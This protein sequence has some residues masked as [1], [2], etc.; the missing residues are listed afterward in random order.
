M[1]LGT[2]IRRKHQRFC[3]LCG[4]V[5][6]GNPNKRSRGR[7][8]SCAREIQV[9]PKHRPSVADHHPDPGIIGGD[10]YGNA[11]R[12]KERFKTYGVRKECRSCPQSCKQYNAPNGRI[13]LC[14]AM[15]VRI[16]VDAL[17]A[18][19]ILITETVDHNGRRFWGER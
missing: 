5:L 16:W 3:R 6:H 17:P 14:P 10:F 9:H 8:L 18:T 11:V 2:S 4:S 15:D 13:V 12:V 1:K 19:R 7:C